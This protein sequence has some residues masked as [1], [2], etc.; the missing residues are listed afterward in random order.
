MTS[1]AAQAYNIPHAIPTVP[2]KPA[3][4]PTEEPE[5]VIEATAIQGRKR[6]ADEAGL[7]AEAE[8][9]AKKLKQDSNGVIVLE[10]DVDDGVIDLD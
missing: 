9:E 10:D 4:L 3:P 6:S 8:K 2:E 1:D 7:E 5:P